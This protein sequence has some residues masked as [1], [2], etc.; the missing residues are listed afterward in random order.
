MNLQIIRGIVIMSNS[1]LSS[2]TQTKDVVVFTAHKAASMFV[3]SVLKQ[4][5]EVA[6][7]QLF[8][9]NLHNIPDGPY[10]ID[11]C[12]LISSK[13]NCI[14]GPL[15]HFCELTAWNQRNIILHL[16]DPRDVLTSLYFS[17]AYSHKVNEDFKTTDDYRD[18]IVESG[19]DNYVLQNAERFVSL[20][21]TYCNEL[22]PKENVKFLKYEDMVSDFSTWIKEFM[23]MFEFPGRDKLIAAYI[24]N[25]QRDQ[26][27]VVKE[28]DVN[29]HRRQVTPGDHKRKLSLETID[30]LNQDFEPILQKLNY[31]F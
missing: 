30:K 11:Q 25:N 31:Q 14:I 12:K 7:I 16:R 1:K 28:E 13:E 24:K 6:N 3:F 9:P 27:F 8:S 26:Y 2:S 10:D 23:E 4:I 19:I 20:Y 21:N 17:M 15:R 18:K 22:L 29:S 5:S